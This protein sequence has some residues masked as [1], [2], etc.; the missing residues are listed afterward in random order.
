MENFTISKKRYGDL[1][2]LDRTNAVNLLVFLLF[3]ADEKGVLI[4]SIRTISTE[5]NIG[6]WTVRELLKKMY[7][8]QILTHQ[9]THQGSEIIICDID[10]YKRKLFEPHTPTHTPTHTQKKT[11]EE[12]KNEFAEKLKPYLEKYGRDTLNNFY[13]YWT[14]VNDGGVKMLF[15]K[16]K[17]FQIPNR[18]AT[19]RKHD[20]GL[21]G[22]INTGI[23]IHD[24]KNKDYE[25]GWK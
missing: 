19:W 20:N 10:S 25:K 24:T 21:Q 6:L 4:V 1:M 23:I 22:G 16:Q 2:K 3:R 14:Q 9:L 17:A 8:S 18:L 15:E 13:Q 7:A 11:I 5:L 12:R